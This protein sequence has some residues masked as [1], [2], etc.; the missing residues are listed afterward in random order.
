MRNFGHGRVH[1]DMRR[2]AK[3]CHNDMR[4]G[5]ASSRRSGLPQHMLLR[6]RGCCGVLPIVRHLTKGTT[7]VEEAS[8]IMMC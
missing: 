6:C 3:L 7:V 2:V 8:C 1:A 5:P 4:S